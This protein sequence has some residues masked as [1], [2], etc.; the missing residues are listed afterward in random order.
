MQPSEIAGKMSPSYKLV[1]KYFIASIFGFIVLTFLMFLNADSF[2]GYHFQPV[3]L[4]L[5]HIAT[6][7]W[8]TMIVFGAM[9]Q[10]VPVVLQVKL[11]SEKL[12]EVQ[13]WIFLFGLIGM[14]ISFFR[15]NTFLLTIFA[16]L[17]SLAILLFIFNTT[18]SMM[19]V[20][21]WNIT[22]TY[23][24]AALFYLLL[25]IAAGIMMAVNLY[26][27][28]FRI[29]HL[30]YL[31][32]HAHLAFVGWVSIVI[33]GVSYKLIP[34]FSLSHGFS[35]KPAKWVFGFI[36]AGLILLTIEYHFSER[37]IMLPIGAVF[38]G[39]GNLIFL[40]QVYLIMEN[41]VRKILD[42]GLTYSMLSFE[43]MFLATMLGLFLVLENFLLPEAFIKLVLI[44]GYLILFGYFSM[45]IVGQMY[46][47]VPFLVWYHKFSAKVGLEPVPML[48]D[49]F[50]GNI[51]RVEFMFMNFAL[52]GTIA[53]IAF[54]NE[55]LM[56]IST[57]VMFLTSIMFLKNMFSIFLIKGIQNGK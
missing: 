44:Y 13:F 9:F 24:A 29:N 16:S 7:G 42:V 50:N 41:R 52:V 5:T 8:I 17:V 43:M 4:G 34:M 6:L 45:I 28:Y 10:L 48:K 47:I 56:Y 23:I 31:K 32:V 27:P 2:K 51:A 26:H 14:V 11:F 33:M 21:E 54:S 38:I 18:A 46:K 3:L 36:N 57:A 53:A 12:A 22:A 30:E 19:K 15:F 1:R 55:T 35:L 49:M 25:T 20:K 40:Y 39:I 37:T